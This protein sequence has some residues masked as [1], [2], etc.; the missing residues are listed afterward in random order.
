MS[1]KEDDLYLSQF[2]SS[3]TGL[4]SNIQKATASEQTDKQFILQAVSRPGYITHTRFVPNP[5]YNAFRAHQFH[6]ENMRSPGPTSYVDEMR[7]SPGRTHESKHYELEYVSEQFQ[8]DKDVV[9]AAVRC[10]GDALQFASKRLQDDWSLRMVSFVPLFAIALD[11][12][13]ASLGLLIASMVLATA[14]TA[15]LSLVASLGIAAVA[16][17]IPLGLSFFSAEP[18]QSQACTIQS[19]PD[20]I[21]G[22][23]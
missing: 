6:R 18:N 23:G 4:T 16:G 1:K 3:S 17:A 22:A 7:H 21:Q 14:L 8:D 13:K 11:Y 5:A 20:L 12:P 2:D 19:E 10:D 15:G 9:L